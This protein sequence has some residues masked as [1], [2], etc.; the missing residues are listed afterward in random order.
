M[1]K[2]YHITCS[3]GV[4]GCDYEDYV[5]LDPEVDD[6]EAYAWEMTLDNAENFAYC[7]FGWGEVPGQDS[8]EYQEYIENCSYYVEEVTKEEYDEFYQN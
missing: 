3:N 8:D 5:A 7:Y 2:Y 6:V 4:C 1:I